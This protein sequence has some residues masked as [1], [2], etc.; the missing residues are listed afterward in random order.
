MNGT[1]SLDNIN[2][3]ILPLFIVSE[4][5]PITYLGM[6]FTVANNLLV[7]CCHCLDVELK[8]DQ[9]IAAIIVS[10]VGN[11]NSI[12]Y[13]TNIDHIQSTYV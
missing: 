1:I 13:L 3:V 12:F 4:K 5:T 2:E 6:G 8:K 11:D 9:Q 7:T 10:E